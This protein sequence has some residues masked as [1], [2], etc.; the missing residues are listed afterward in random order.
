M[1]G[2]H[3]DQVEHNLRDARSALDPLSTLSHLMRSSPARS[4][5]ASGRTG[6][7]NPP[8]MVSG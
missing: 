2:S 1:A 8:P 7:E 4:S 3:L 6:G 5:L